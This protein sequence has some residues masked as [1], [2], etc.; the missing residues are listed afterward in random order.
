MNYKGY[1]I[2]EILIVIAIAGILGA[3]LFAAYKFIAKENVTRVL[4]IKSDDEIN[5]F[6]YQIIKDIETAGFGI[7]KYTPSGT[8]GT[9]IKGNNNEAG[10]MVGNSLAF[11][12]LASREERYSGCWA[13][14]VNIKLPN[15]NL[16]IPRLDIEDEL[17][18][19]E[20][21]S[22]QNNYW[23]KFRKNFF[24]QP[25]HLKDNDNS[26]PANPVKMKANYWYVIMDRAKN[27]KEV[28]GLC[29]DGLCNCGSGNDIKC[30][31]YYSTGDDTTKSYYAFFATQQNNYKY[32]QDFKVQYFIDTD[33]ESPNICASGTYT[34]FKKV[35]SNPKQQII[36]C[37]FPD[38]LRFRAGRIDNN[39]TIDYTTS[40]QDI[41][42]AITYSKL[43][44]LKMCL[45]VQIGGRQDVIAS[46]K[47]QF[48]S[49]CGN[50]PNIT[51][52]WWNST[53][54]YY[55]WRVIERDIPLYN[56]Q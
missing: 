4:T 6:L 44:T 35:G 28:D 30:E 48:S 31:N 53:G 23:G 27:K 3:G 24:W 50:N 46:Q 10:I 51:D 25:C 8:P 17:T 43:K 37:I 49:D 41:R 13:I 56:F 54:R 14:I 36:S 55:K 45:I 5:S 40:N 34:L 12:S 2:I 38:G 20:G 26:D 33:M 15:S 52:T 16:P 32:P 19:I 1:S 18:T 29:S 42:D 39:G 7:E 22:T 9:L 11:Y 21:Q 47:P